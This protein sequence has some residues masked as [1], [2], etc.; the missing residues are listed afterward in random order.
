MNPPLISVVSP[1]YNHGE[2]LP[3]MI[4]SCLGQ[5]YPHWELIIIDDGSTDNSLE[6]AKRYADKHRNITLLI[7]GENQGAIK[8]VNRGLRETRGDFVLMRS[9]DDVNLPGYFEA[10][11]CLLQNHPKAALFCADIAYYRE[12]IEKGQVE[13]LNLCPTPGFCPPNRI[14]ETMGLT[15]IHG[16]TVMIRRELLEESGFFQENHGW[17]NDWLPYMS[18]AY[19]KGVCYSPHPYVG[20][21][22]LS[23]SFSAQSSAHEENQKTV[24]ANIITDIVTDHP[25]ILDTFIQSGALG[26]FGPMLMPAIRDNPFIAKALGDRFTEIETIIMSRL[27]TIRN[28]GIH[29]IINRVLTNHYEQ[30]VALQENEGKIW[31]YGGGLHTSLLLKCWERLG[32]EP[33]TG[34]L[35]TQPPKQS[36]F[37]NIPLRAANAT[38][39]DDEDL[40]I[41]S[42]KSYEQE[43]ARIC[44]SLV[45]NANILTFWVPSNNRFTRGN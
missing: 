41:I 2:F 43:I 26:F 17:Y 31:I 11:V 10:G 28:N 14:V 23:G 44:H 22:L 40:I 7:N 45:P 36:H 19:R 33:P 15:P 32:L 27:S 16:H 9:A 3:D 35:L 29:E 37:E 4:E 13:C 30:I 25:D 24:I 38:L 5:S 34:I 20:C 12:S 8:S 42:S 21:R 18:W 1:S 6:I 39:I